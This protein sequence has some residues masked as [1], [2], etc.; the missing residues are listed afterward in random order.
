MIGYNESESYEIRCWPDL[1]SGEL[2]QGPNSHKELEIAVVMHCVEQLQLSMLHSDSAENSRSLDVHLS[3]CE[4]FV[5]ASRTSIEKNERFIQDE[6]VLM[7][8]VLDVSTHIGI[9]FTRSSVMKLWQ[10]YECLP[11]RVPI[12]EAEDEGWLFLAKEVDNFYLNLIALDLVTRWCHSVDTVSMEEMMGGRQSHN[13]SFPNDTPSE[14]RSFIEV[15][16]HL[17]ETMCENFCT[18]IRGRKD[19]PILAQFLCDVT[20]FN[21]VAWDSALSI[22]LLFERV[23]VPRLLHQHSFCTLRE[24]VLLGSEYI[25]KDS[26]HTCLVD[27]IKGESHLPMSLDVSTT[28]ECKEILGPLF[29]EISSEISSLQRFIDSTTFMKNALQCDE[30]LIP[31]K[32]DF[33]SRNPIDFIQSILDD[34][35]RV[36]IMDFPDWENRQFSLTAN[37][38]ISKFLTQVEF[39]DEGD[40]IT[41]PPLPAGLVLHLAAL[42]GLQDARSQFLVKNRIILAAL[43]AGFNGAA[44]A[45][46][47]VLLHDASLGEKSGKG[48]DCEAS[49]ILLTSIASIVSCDSFTDHRTKFDLCARSLQWVQEKHLAKEVGLASIDTILKTLSL[50]ENQNKDTAKFPTSQR[51][52]EIPNR[53]QPCL[54]SKIQDMLSHISHSYQDCHS[55]SILMENNPFTNASV[56][57]AVI[58]WCTNEALYFHDNDCC[59]VMAIFQL[60]LAL[61]MDDES[62]D[63]VQLVKRALCSFESLEQNALESYQSEAQS[64]NQDIVSELV[65]RGY[66]ENGSRRSAMMTKNSSF[67][68]ALVWAVA[69]FADNNFD[70]PFLLLKEEKSQTGKKVKKSCRN[71][72]ILLSMIQA[73]KRSIHILNHKPTSKRSSLCTE[74]IRDESFTNADSFDHNQCIVKS[75]KTEKDTNLR[76]S[77]SFD[78]DFCTDDLSMLDVNHHSESQMICREQKVS[79]VEERQRL[80][81]EGRKILQLAEP[82]E[83][84]RLTEEGRKI[85]EQARKLR[86]S[87]KKEQK[88]SG[89]SQIK[90]QKGEFQSKQKNSNER[91]KISVKLMDSFHSK[92]NVTKNGEA[93]G[94]S[95]A[96]EAEKAR[97]AEERRLAEEAAEQ[98]RLEEERRLAEEAEKARIKYVAS[99]EGSVSNSLVD[100]WGSEDDLSL[101]GLSSSDL[102]DLVHNAEKCVTNSGMGSVDE[103]LSD[104]PSGSNGSGWS[105]EDVK[106]DDFE[107]VTNG[108]EVC[109]DKD[110]GEGWGFDF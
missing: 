77:F 70:D 69:H 108:N 89:R 46:C 63:F 51:T 61:L 88:Q 47:S 75:M 101:D 18:K 107:G 1:I 5:R 32:I 57:D 2:I 83:K 23:L 11:M 76:G 38:D 21:K 54:V 22:T 41:L 36:I 78:D 42:M 60:T 82:R 73:I 110:V 80:T 12:L 37:L 86:L 49:E 97:I 100:G 90:I 15:G 102:L 104:N 106:N 58:S 71:Q 95:L 3:V 74:T 39:T 10:M 33:S 28:N 31:S 34:N 62:K 96:E 14:T 19:R 56:F 99:D 85:L 59:E 79:D 7:Q 26:L 72:I 16:N 55:I 6:T 17:L 109:D 66:S 20:D 30:H 35:P 91:V 64:P 105:Y 48:I 4:A 53:N 40:N 27:F 98:M 29:P 65:Q 24:I 67:K 92:Q 13:A 45:L 43:E 50:L 52:H 87:K 81:N 84:K 94:R 8:F 93:K 25:A 68:D 103:Q 9:S 44:A